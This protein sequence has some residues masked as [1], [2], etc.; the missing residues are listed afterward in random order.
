MGNNAGQFIEIKAQ[1]DLARRWENTR[2]EF[3][4]GFSMTRSKQPW[5][6]HI[7]LTQCS[8]RAFS[9]CLQCERKAL[10]VQFICI[11][12]FKSFC[13][14]F[15][16]HAHLQHVWYHRAAV[17]IIWSSVI[18]TSLPQNGLY[19]GF[20]SHVRLGINSQT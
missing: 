12:N 13:W 1:R 14:C 7:R 16:Q 3:L 11:I 5:H 8:I 10:H 6:I 20:I 4:L 17:R 9:V 15:Q 18:L 19:A 2:N